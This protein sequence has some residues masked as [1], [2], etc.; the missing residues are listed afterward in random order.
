MAKRKR[1][2]L[3]KHR[4]YV[5]ARID[6]DRPPDAAEK[7]GY[8]RGTASTL[9]SNPHIQ[10]AIRAGLDEVWDL[11]QVEAA[12]LVRVCADILMAEV[13]DILGADGE[14]LPPEQWPRGV[15]LAVEG[16]K[17]KELVAHEDGVALKVGTV[18]DVKLMRKKDAVSEIARLLGLYAPD[19]VDITGG[20]DLAQALAQARARAAE[21]EAEGEGE[22]E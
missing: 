4:R 12:D 3:E 6:G 10:E 8:A 21:A 19:K 15:R 22:G 14:L 2:L 11:A 16:L 7:A 5:R 17:V 13:P 20:D 18:T 1:R 9:E